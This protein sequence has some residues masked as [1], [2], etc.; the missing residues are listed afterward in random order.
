MEVRL[1]EVFHLL[2]EFDRDECSFQQ[3]LAFGNF[4]GVEWTLFYLREAFGLFTADQ[5]T[6]INLSQFL[7]FTVSE[8]NGLDILSRCSFH[9]NFVFI[10]FLFRLYEE[11]E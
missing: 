8:L 9:F 7:Q 3:L 1:K 6:T 2:D 4:I 5:Q 10:S 11:V